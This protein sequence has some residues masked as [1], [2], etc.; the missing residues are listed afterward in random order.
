[1]VMED[2]PLNRINTKA[3]IPEIDILEMSPEMIAFLDEE[4]PIIRSDREQLRHLALAVIESGNF[5]LTYDDSTRT[6]KETFEMRQGN[7]LAFTN[8]FIAMARHLGLNAIFQE[9]DVPPAWTITGQSYIFSQHIN[10]YVRLERGFHQ[11]VDFNLYEVDMDHDTR[12]ISDDRARAHYFNNIGAERMLAGESGAAYRYLRE[13]L[14]HDMTFTPAWVNMGILHRREGLVDWA[15]ASYFQALELDPGNL[16][17]LSNLVNLYEENGMTGLAQQYLKR[18][19][20]HRMRNPYYRYHKANE[21]FI[22][23]DY[24]TAIEDLKY[25]IRLRRNEDRF[26]YLLSLCYLMQGNKSAATEWMK[27]AEAVAQTNSEKERY[28]YKLDQLRGLD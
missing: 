21:A 24:D 11:V 12:L 8:M 22:E 13:S 7:C 6:A 14:V 5:E 28:H 16:M 4:V 9:V 3:D 1:M 17:A 25:A 10:V 27:K 20:N 26:Y 18:V 15:E 23:G 19:Q 2:S